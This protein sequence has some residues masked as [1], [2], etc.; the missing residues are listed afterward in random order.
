MPFSESFFKD[1]ATAAGKLSEDCT[2][3]RLPGVFRGF[4]VTLIKPDSD[5]R[6]T[7]AMKFKD[8]GVDREGSFYLVIQNLWGRLPED[9]E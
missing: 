5:E 2:M 3:V 8:I 6:K 4:Y 7:V 1:V 9:E